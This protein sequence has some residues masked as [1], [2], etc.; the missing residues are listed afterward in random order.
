MGLFDVI[1]SVF[2]IGE[3]TTER[4]D[5]TTPKEAEETSVA[6]EREPGDEETTEAETAEESTTEHEA[7]TVEE[8]V[9]TGTDAAGSTGSMV[10]EETAAGDVASAAEPAE[11]V[12]PE[13]EALTADVAESG[14][15]TESASQA[16][17]PP[18]QE[19]KGIGPAYSTRLGDVGIVTV[20]DLAEAD[21]E[22]LA[23]QTGL[24]DSRIGEWIK[25][26]REFA[27]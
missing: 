7:E 12:G 16:E 2:S 27:A 14:P 18:V 1:K 21:P 19:I 20:G 11:A 15:D 25:R 8:P 9:A 23:A 3:T 6:V 13:S 17:E 4:T 5:G 26:A 24:S 22:E 10:D